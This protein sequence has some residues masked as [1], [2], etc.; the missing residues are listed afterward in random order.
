MKIRAGFV[1]NSSSSSFCLYGIKIEY[2]DDLIIP[3]NLTNCSGISDISE[4]EIVIGLSPDSIDDN[5]TGLEFKTRIQNI[6]KENKDN[7]KLEDEDLIF[8]WYQ[9]GGY[10]G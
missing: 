2:R 5:E 3:K 1:S 10:D 6:I 4:D 7:L 9:D 8:A